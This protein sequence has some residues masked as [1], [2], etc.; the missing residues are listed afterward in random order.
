LDIIS[1][2]D[3]LARAGSQASLTDELTPGSASSGA[4][5]GGK[6]NPKRRWSTEMRANPQGKSTNPRSVPMSAVPRSMSGAPVARSA[7][8]ASAGASVH[9]LPYNPRF[10]LSLVG[11]DEGDDEPLEDQPFESLEDRPVLRQATARKASHHSMPNQ[12]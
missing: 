7:S 10:S 1:Q 9:T 6:G 8:T 2:A 3:R 4:N 11:D 5:L 12:H